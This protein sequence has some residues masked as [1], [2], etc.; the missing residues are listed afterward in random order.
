MKNSIKISR[1]EL[2][3]KVWSYP[4]TRLC[5]EFN[6]SDNGLRKICTKH[7][8]PLPIAGYWSKIKFGK[9]VIKTELP[10]KDNVAIII[11]IKPA[12]NKLSETFPD[13]LSDFPDLILIIPDKLENPDRITI[14][15]KHDLIKKKPSSNNNRENVIATSFTSE[16]PDVVISKDNL[17]RA[18]LIIDTLIKNFR[19]VGLKVYCKTEGLFIE[20]DEGEKKKISLAEKCT[21]KTV[22]QGTYNWERR[23]F[24]PNGKLK[25]RI[26]DGYRD[27][28]FTDTETE[29]I[30]K[31]R[32][33]IGRS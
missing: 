9:K 29:P 1:K 22:V 23:L 3:E 24:F 17:N 16:L 30:E 13:S 25:L 12:E 6:L 27:A 10:V 14:A 33:F 2:Y 7:D 8:I 4:L 20:N 21:A 5:K 26:G 31:R 11:E 19:K 18:I 15:L 32:Q 28:E